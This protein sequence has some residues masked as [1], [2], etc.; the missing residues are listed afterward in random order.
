MVLALLA[1]V[2]LAAGGQAGPEGMAPGTDAISDPAANLLKF[3]VHR[4][5]M[6]CSV[7]TG[8]LRYCLK[9]L[10]ARGF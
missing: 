2:L 5:A 10:G 8:A 3:T 4:S 1:V 9:K 6:P 7:S